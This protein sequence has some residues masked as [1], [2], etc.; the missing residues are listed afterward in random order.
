LVEQ[1]NAVT[2]RGG[3]RAPLPPAVASIQ[4]A[5][6]DNESLLTLSGVNLGR[7][8]AVRVYA[9]NRSLMGDGTITAQSDAKIMVR[10]PSELA[11]YARYV[12]LRTDARVST[13]CDLGAY[14]YQDGVVPGVLCV[15]L[16]P[17]SLGD[18]PL[19]KLMPLAELPF[20]KDLRS[21]LSEAG[22]VGVARVAGSG[23]PTPGSSQNA[24][25][26]R[27][28]PE[29]AEDVC[30]AALAP[31][32]AVTV[33]ASALHGCSEVRSVGAVHDSY[34]LHGAPTDSH[35][36]EQWALHPVAGL[37]CGFAA[38]TARVDLNMPSAW[39]YTQETVG[40][41]IG[42]FDT[43]IESPH[44][45]MD[46][47][48]DGMPWYNTTC[49]PSEGEQGSN[50]WRAHGTCV[51]S[52]AGA[53]ADNT[54]GIA[55]VGFNAVPISVKVIQ[56]DSCEGTNVA[57]VTAGLAEVNADTAA[58][59]PIYNMSFGWVRDA[60]SAAEKRALLSR[61][62]Q[63]FRQGKLLVASVGNEQVEGVEIPAG[64]GSFVMGIGAVLWNGLY[65]KDAFVHGALDTLWNKGENWGAGLDV[66][67]PGGRLIVVDAFG[68]SVRTTVA[69]NAPCDCDPD[70][71][72]RLAF[73][74]TSAA[75][76]MVSGLAAWLKS[77]EPS[78]Q[79]E[80]L[81]HVIVA[82][83]RRY[84]GWEWNDHYGW[85]IPDGGAATAYVAAPRL[86][87]HD[88]MGMGGGQLSVTERRQVPMRLYNCRTLGGVALGDTVHTCMRYRMSGGRH[89]GGMFTGAV[90]AWVR[91]AACWGLRDTVRFDY[92]VDTFGGN[93]LWSNDSAYVDTYVYQV[94]DADSVWYPCDTTQ[95]QVAL[96]MVGTQYGC[97]I[98]GNAGALE[99]RIA[100]APNPSASSRRIALELPG[101]S[102][103]RLEVYDVAGRRVARIAE[104]Q[105][106]AG[107]HV[108]V[109]DGA[110][111]GG[112][113]VGA[114]V[115]FCRVQGAGA[116]KTARMVVLGRR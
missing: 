72:D 25:G 26:E 97:G 37:L 33:V 90:D 69:D 116:A 61:C 8:V 70:E 7:V 22:V 104:G 32:S 36:W 112:E 17:G 9:H 109:W 82:T 77:V 13:T 111:D 74:G 102:Y 6:E 73:G 24:L 44:S 40:V 43:G 65:W 48:D 106:G 54:Y 68:E 94:L 12:V 27:I 86:V 114:G 75:A 15:V 63:A 50:C 18:A 92:D 78:L 84:A 29:A 103:V 4:V 110:S 60:L 98:E 59:I 38:P 41:R 52:I 23:V 55:G 71:I 58:N 100:T 67:A 21:A 76:P 113:R 91:A 95:V 30:I 47:W 11:K 81:E 53:V 66:V 87:A 64:F 5:S 19:G 83:A 56:E 14:G 49:E 57:S 107:A 89:Y 16:A 10:V 80:D 88:T 34:C 79:G 31:G 3:Y 45:D 93:L 39:D 62:R 42:I 28:W 108:F 85:G 46:T 20:A 99:L 1:T 35:Y 105:M 96:T 115:Y 51:A 2:V 101:A